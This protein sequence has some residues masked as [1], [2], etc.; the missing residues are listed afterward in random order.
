MRI[1]L[2]S[3]KM[4]D[5][6]QI[7]RMQV[8]SFMKLLHKYKDYDTNPAA[9]TVEKI[10]QRMLQD[11]TDYYFICLNNEKIGVIRVVRVTD[12]T[13]RI[14]PIF[15]EPKYQGKGYATKVMIKVEGYYPN[16]QNWELDTIKQEERLCLFYEKMGYKITG[17]EKSIKE[18]MTIIDYA[19]RF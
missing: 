10:E 8:K 14:S 11:F 5:C 17:K 2:Q 7:H 12:N 18:G 6:T 4:Q 3:A 9:E 16:V 19:K 1:S 15:I 13:C